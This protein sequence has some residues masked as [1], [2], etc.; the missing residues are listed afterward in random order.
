MVA[1]G[2]AGNLPCNRRNLNE[3]LRYHHS[4]VTV[5]RQAG[6]LTRSGMINRNKHNS[7][8][9]LIIVTNRKTDKTMGIHTPDLGLL[10]SRRICQ[11]RHDTEDLTPRSKCP[12]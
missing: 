11:Q 10:K 7:N 9:E 2:H 4:Q 3:T 6:T 1:T 5:P 8:H 12:E